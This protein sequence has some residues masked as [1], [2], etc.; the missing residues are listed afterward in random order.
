MLVEYTR[1]EGIPSRHNRVSRLDPLVPL[2]APEGLVDPVE[3]CGHASSD[4]ASRR[5]SDLNHDLGS[6]VL[7]VPLPT[8]V[9]LGHR[10]TIQHSS[11]AKGHVLRG[12][13]DSLLRATNHCHDHA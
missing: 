2:D 12:E 8:G 10:V 9:L 13:P 1:V 4:V 3:Q 5:T 6:L 7:V 11:A